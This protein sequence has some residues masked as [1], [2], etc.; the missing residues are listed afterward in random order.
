[1][2]DLRSTKLRRWGAGLVL[3][4][5]AACSDVTGP[6]STELLQEQGLSLAELQQQVRATTARV[7][8]ILREN[9]PVARRVAIKTGDELAEEERLLGMVTGIAVEGTEGTLTLAYGAQVTFNGETGFAG[10]GD[11]ALGFEQFVGHMTEALALGR[12]P[13]IKAVRPPPDAPQDPDDTSFRAALIRVTDDAVPAMLVLNVDQDN[14]VRMD[15]PPPDAILTVLGLPIEIR[16]SEGL[17]ELILDRDQR[18]EVAFEGEVLEVRENGLLVHLRHL[19]RTIVVRVVDRTRLG[20][21]GEAITSLAPVMRALEAGQ[22]VFAVGEGI[23]ADGEATVLAIA[24]RFKTVE[25]RETVSFGGVVREVD[26]AAGLLALVEGPVVQIGPDTRLKINGEPVESL[27]RIVTALEA[28]LTVW[29][30]GEGVVESGSDRVLAAFVRFEVDDGTDRVEFAGRVGSVDLEAGTFAI[31][32]GPTITVGDQTTFADGSA[33]AG[34]GGVA[35]ALATGWAVYVEGWGVI[36][37]D[38]PR[39]IAAKVVK[40]RV[41]D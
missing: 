3:A 2:S 27:A 39:V 6:G 28:G 25:G 26:A 33:L 32:E 7:E 13:R 30:F 15:P 20:F 9:G 8:I 31:V 12:E 35:E 14:L 18:H 29:A 38:E 1:M 21:N 19:D 17:T 11:D 36:V 34:L 22:K 24:I 41:Q 23:R 16:V 40:F 10:L 37:T 4:S 5:V